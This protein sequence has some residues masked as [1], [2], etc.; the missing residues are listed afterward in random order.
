MQPLG[1]QG[2]RSAPRTSFPSS[3]GLGFRLMEVRGGRILSFVKLVRLHGRHR[4]RVNPATVKSNRHKP[5]IP[6]VY[7]V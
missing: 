7:A 3:S 4:R 1:S 5:C 2:H 6:T